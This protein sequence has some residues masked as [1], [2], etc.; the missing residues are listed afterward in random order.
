MAH[1]IDCLDKVL[2]ILEKDKEVLDQKHREYGG[3]CFKR[4]GVGFFMMLAR[5]WDR[6]EV[7]VK[8]VDWDIFFAV[9][10]DSREE[11]VLDDIRDL[12]RYLALAEAYINSN[13]RPSTS[14]GNPEDL[15][16]SKQL[17]GRIEQ[18]NPYGYDPNEDGLDESDSF[19]RGEKR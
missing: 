4:G 5:K 19:Y 9:D 8:Q 17:A 15:F 18:A 14:K 12:R 11:G 16:A 6:L 7:A 10:T 13:L 3:S 2:E 1:E